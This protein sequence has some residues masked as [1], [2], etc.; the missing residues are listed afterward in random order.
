MISRGSWTNLDQHLHHDISSTWSATGPEVSC[1]PSPRTRWMPCPCN[2]SHDVLYR[3][4]GYGVKRCI[5]QE[6]SHRETQPVTESENDPQLQR[7]RG[8]VKVRQLQPTGSES[9]DLLR[10]LQS[11]IL[12]GLSKSMRV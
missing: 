7:R 4:D 2:L 8:T 10:N 5:L 11:L 6:V 1:R 12:S 9:G 3:L